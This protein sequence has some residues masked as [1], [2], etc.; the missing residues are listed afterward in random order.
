MKVGLLSVLDQRLGACF[1]EPGRRGH[2]PPV[3]AEGHEVPHKQKA[4]WMA[5]G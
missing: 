5:G 2:V 4:L 3:G 1:P